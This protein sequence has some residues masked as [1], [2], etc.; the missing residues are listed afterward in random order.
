[1]ILLCVTLTHRQHL[2][3]LFNKLSQLN[4][5]DCEFHKNLDRLVK[6]G[7]TDM[8][9]C[10]WAPEAVVTLPDNTTYLAY[11]LMLKR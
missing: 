6:A 11:S 2:I 3:G 10:L 5:K 7:H 1:M 4:K 9:P 8:Q